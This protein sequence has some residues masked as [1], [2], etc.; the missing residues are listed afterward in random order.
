MTTQLRGLEK[1]LDEL[2][3]RLGFQDE[4]I[5]S[6]NAVIARQDREIITMTSQL[7][8]LFARLSDLAEA[9]AP[10][11]SAGDEIPPHY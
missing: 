5:E 11:A 3:S 4:L 2:E 6:L 9:A 1:R 7:K 8:A 10:G